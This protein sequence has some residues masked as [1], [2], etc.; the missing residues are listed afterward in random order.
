MG[1]IKPSI[2]HPL[3]LPNMHFACFLM[4]YLCYSAVWVILLCSDLFFINLH[5]NIFS[6]TQLN[7][8]EEIQQNEI[9][10]RIKKEIGQ[11]PANFIR[12]EEVCSNT[13]L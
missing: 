12:T 8:K 10:K 3:H 9:L 13:Y 7:D 6:A 4:F 11:P 1:Y 2:L 5:L